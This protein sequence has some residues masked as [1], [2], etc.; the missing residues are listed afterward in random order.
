MTD[1]LNPKGHHLIFLKHLSILSKTHDINAVTQEW[2]VGE[3]RFDESTDEILD[4]VNCIQHHTLPSSDLLLKVNGNLSI[5]PHRCICGVH[6]EEHC[7]IKNTLTGH[8]IWV[9]NCCVKHIDAD[10]YEQVNRAKNCLH[11]I[12]EKGID[13]V[14]NKPNEDVIQTAL[15]QG[16]L[17]SNDI[18]FLHSIGR[19]TKLSP[20]Q[21]KWLSDIKKRLIEQYCN[22]DIQLLTK[23]GINSTDTCACG[24]PKK[25]EYQK[26]W[27]C[28]QEELGVN[29][30]DTCDCGKPKKPQF[31]QCWSCAHGGGTKSY[32]IS[33]LKGLVNNP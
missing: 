1:L 14:G 7:L 25:P 17:T 32:N 18:D 27:L 5:L 19:K 30:S 8:Q 33:L 2:Q 22:H 10:I 3:I 13:C 15:K 6:I 21:K 20:K 23:S 31:S 4:I 12:I 11:T 9:G 29:T 26:C 16:I 24:K 28:S